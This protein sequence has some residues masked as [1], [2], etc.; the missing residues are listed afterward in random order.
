MRKYWIILIASIGIAVWAIYA[1]VF[2]G[3]VAQ[4]TNHEAMAARSK[5]LA[6]VLSFVFL[7]ALVVVVVCIARLFQL[8]RSRKPTA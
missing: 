4:T 7:A 3:W 6:D 5:S 8:R 2:H 1:T